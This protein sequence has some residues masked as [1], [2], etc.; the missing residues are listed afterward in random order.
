VI[1][2]RKLLL[3]LIALSLCGGPTVAQDY[4][5]TLEFHFDDRAIVVPRFGSRVEALPILELIGAEAKLSL[6]AGTY[7]V[8]YDTHVIQFAVEHRVL[9]VDG[10]LQEAREA[11]VTSPGG[12]AVSLSYLERWL[13]SPLGFHLEP[14]ARGYRVARG[15]RFADPVTLRPVAADFGSTT[16]L[17]LTLSRET[18]AG[19]EQ[20][21]EG[22][23]VVRFDDATPQLDGSVPF[24][25]RRVLSITSIDQLVEVH[26][27]PGIGLLSW[28]ALDGPPRVTMELGPVRATPTPAPVRAPVVR[29]TGP[30]PVVIDPGHGG[31]DI[32]ARSQDGVLTEKDIT[33]A[34][35]R[36]LARVLES[37]GQAVRLTRDGDQSRALTDRTALA[38]RLE[39]PVFVS[40]HANASTFSS[41]TGTETYYMSLDS[42]S[43]EAA[44]ATADL[45]NRAGASSG[46][47]SALDLI[48]WDLAQ[49]EVLNESAQLAL[50]VQGRLNSRLGLRDRGVKQAPFV[51]LTGATMPAILVEVGFLSNPSEAE[52][53]TQ[54]E[55]QQQIAEALAAGIEDFVRR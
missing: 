17:V 14:I 48:L 45:E 50:A 55:Y 10:E 8:L 35:A 38:N 31:D 36:R 5:R 9:L 12:V 11:P 46:E 13:L 43:D 27:A 24:R 33:L 6:S 3:A 52:R 19:V 29:R 54:P 32:G 49:A 7:G 22:R 42:A 26:L 37:R 4:D 30:R 15:A 34:V 53:L 28:H 16:T 40:L 21:E 47:K 51:V 2:K 20:A 39:A 23:I 25:S 44:A 18:I 1:L 41:V